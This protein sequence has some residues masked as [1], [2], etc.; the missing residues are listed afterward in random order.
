M[1]EEQK[2]LKISFRYFPE[3][4]EMYSWQESDKIGCGTFGTVYKA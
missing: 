4:K 3:F 2:N 1:S